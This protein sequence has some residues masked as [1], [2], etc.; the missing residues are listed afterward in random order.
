[1]NK[2]TLILILLISASLLFVGCKAKTESSSKDEPKISAKEEFYNTL[3]KMPSEYMVE[4]TIVIQDFPS[5]SR[6]YIKGDNFRADTKSAEGEGF[7][8][9]KSGEV[10]SCATVQGELTCFKIE[11][12]EVINPLANFKELYK[13]VSEE[14]GFEIYRD[15]EMKISGET[16]KCYKVIIVTEETNTTQRSCVSDEGVLLYAKNTAGEDTIAFEATD[17]SNKVSDSMFVVPA[18]AKIMDMKDMFGR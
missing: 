11:N 18:D 15:G 14:P 10:T 2:K 6:M 4:Y 13:K 7:M 16:A 1:M 12:E 5:T 17:Y 8:I 3:L 9:L